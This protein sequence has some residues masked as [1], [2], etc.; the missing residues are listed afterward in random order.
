MAD[1]LAVFSINISRMIDPE[2]IVF[3]G[4]MAN[5]GDALLSKIKLHYARRTWT[6]LPSDV[7]LSIAASCNNA[8]MIGAAVAASRL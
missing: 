7:K 8:G 4:G 2:V 5:A 1:Y 6:V 3:A